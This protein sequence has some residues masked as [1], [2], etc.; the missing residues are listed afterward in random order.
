MSI[1]HHSS[2]VV[3]YHHRRTKLYILLFNDKI[4]FTNVNSNVI[5]YEIGDCVVF[6]LGLDIIVGFMNNNN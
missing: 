6:P 3:Q 1:S 2:I 5:G 4:A